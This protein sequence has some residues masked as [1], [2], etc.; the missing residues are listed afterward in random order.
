MNLILGQIHTGVS[1]SFITKT[2][3]MT[4]EVDTG[5]IE[6]TFDFTVAEDV[7]AE[8]MGIVLAEFE[9]AG[10]AHNYYRDNY[11][12]CGKPEDKCCENNA[13]ES[14]QAP[15]WVQKIR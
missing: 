13:V 14:E 3:E 6:K 2:V 8:E 12:I 4:P 9:N 15:E 7:D 10:A 5:N 11:F 1:Q